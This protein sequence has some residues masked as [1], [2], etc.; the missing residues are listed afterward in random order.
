[1]NKTKFC[2][3]I[4]S[5][6]PSCAKLFPI[7][8]AY[9]LPPSK[10]S[11]CNVRLELKIKRVKHG[12]EIPFTGADYQGVQ[13]AIDGNDPPFTLAMVLHLR[14]SVSG[15]NGTAGTVSIPLADPNGIIVTYGKS[16]D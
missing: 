3:T 15:S 1:M 16:C 7:V 11:S 14:D 8:S 6:A 4:F 9:G 5:L 2:S 10:D 12:K 13:D